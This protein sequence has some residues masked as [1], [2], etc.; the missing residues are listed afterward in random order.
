MDNSYSWP[1]GIYLT[2]ICMPQGIDLNLET[3]LTGCLF[4]KPSPHFAKEFIS[5]HL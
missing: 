5:E 3:Q 4:L 1:C 2:V